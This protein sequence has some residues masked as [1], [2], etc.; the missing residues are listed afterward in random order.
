[1]GWR[2]LVEVLKEAER[3]GG[4]A[5]LSPLVTTVATSD[6]RSYRKVLQQPWVSELAREHVILG[7]VG[8]QR[9]GGAT[10]SA[11]AQRREGGGRGV[12]GLNEEM[13][14]QVLTVM[15][16]QL[17]EMTDKVNWLIRC[18]KEKNGVGLGLGLGGGLNVENNRSVI[19]GS[20]IKQVRVSLKGRKRY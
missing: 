7:A 1:M 6:T 18:I 4:P 20:L 16:S 11:S 17:G 19:S 9:S 14:H 10:V 15:K 2:K 8:L 13:V 5:H 3:E 12:V